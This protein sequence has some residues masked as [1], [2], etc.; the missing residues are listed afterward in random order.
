[1]LPPASKLP[2]FV[3]M[4]RWMTDPDGCLERDAARYGEAYL[5]KSTLFG[6]EAIF[7]HPAALKEIFTGDPERFVAGEANELLGPLL[8]DRSVLL[9]D[10]AEHL[11]VRRMM[12]P[13]FHGERMRCYT[14]VMREATARAIGSLRP[15]DHVGLHGLFQRIT[16][17]VILNTVLGLDEEGPELTQAR[18][19][20]THLLD[21]VQSPSGALWMIPALRR[22]VYGHGPWASIK[23]EIEAL[24]RTLL[25]HIAARRALLVEKDDVLAMLIRAV[26]ENGKGL[27]DATLCCQLK[28]LLIA[29]HETSATALGWAFEELLREPGEQERLTAEV[30]RVT[31]GTALTAEHL[32]KLERLDSVIKETLRLHPVTGA[33][34]RILKKPTTIAGF[35]LPAGTFIVA[36][37]H[38]THRRP[39]LYPQPLRFMPE[40]FIG[41]KLDPYEWLP[42]GGGVRRCL[43]MAFSLHEMKV[44]MATMFGAG[45]EL[46][47]A[48]RGP[49]KATL[50]SL[51][52][53]PRG[54][55]KVI[56]RARA[57][58]KPSHSATMS[59]SM[60]IE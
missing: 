35:D 10:G 55:T 37:A 11:H 42:F 39:D 50:R 52:Y 12:M 8:G 33:V 14:D 45:I 53:S 29:G 48:N 56:V 24:D 43:G 41:K 25:A 40:R 16:L 22:E 34:G 44:I 2:G 6:V 13:A 47:L 38:V 49:V 17:D 9:L 3:N 19:Q 46:R 51:I 28:T 32:P 58:K 30:A 59:P 7:N 26:D 23:R 60:P 54:G 18:H 57:A 27:D 5:M 15:G 4:I 36:C 31:G 21:R 20:I 1:M